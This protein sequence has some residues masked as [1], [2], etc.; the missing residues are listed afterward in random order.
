MILLIDDDQPYNE[1]LTDI[2]NS[3]DGSYQIQTFTTGLDA[4][5]WLREWRKANSLPD[6][7]IMDMMIPWDENDFGGSGMPDNPPEGFGGVRV[8]KELLL[9]GLDPNRVL[10]ISAVRSDDLRKMLL[11]KKV[12]EHQILLK[13]ARTSEIT[14]KVK[15]IHSR[16][17]IQ[18]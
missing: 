17:R 14:Q 6:V 11:E 9:M 2:L 3:E 18:N 1:A 15:L 4:I 7:V 8:L 5:N 13:P 16:S 10:V 12:P